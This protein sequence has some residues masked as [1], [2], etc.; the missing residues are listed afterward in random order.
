MKIKATLVLGS[1]AAI[2][3]VSSVAMV[4]KTAS[5]TGDDAVA[6]VTKLENDA[7]KAD[8]ANDKSFYV[9]VLAPDWTGGDSS[10]QWFTKKAML[11]MSDDTKNNKMN[12][13]K[14]SELKVRAYGNTAVANYKDSYDAMVQGEHRTR[15]V[16]TTDTFVKMG[17]VW[18]EVAS[19]SSQAKK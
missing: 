14:I 6:A 16:L 5:A 7:V 12:S 10:G 2:L 11:D 1:T 13:E 3:L 15:T 18:K 9:K 17:G 8:L 19:H 4:E